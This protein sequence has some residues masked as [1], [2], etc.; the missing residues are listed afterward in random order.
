MKELTADKKFGLY[1][2]AI[3]FASQTYRFSAIDK[4]G[5][6]ENIIF[7]IMLS[8]IIGGLVGFLIGMVYKKI[9]HK[10]DTKH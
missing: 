2:I 7:L 6:M 1:G 9:G 4:H 8:M 10:K 3:G 5:G